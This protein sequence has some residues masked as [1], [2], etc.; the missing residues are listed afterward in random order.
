MKERPAP[1]RML[2]KIMREVASR[3]AAVRSMSA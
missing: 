1:Y 3:G 2:K